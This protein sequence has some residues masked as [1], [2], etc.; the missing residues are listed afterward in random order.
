M[1]GAWTRSL[2]YIDA[3]LELVA[4]SYLASAGKSAYR[5]HSR[6]RTLPHQDCVQPQ[7]RPHPK[8]A[9]EAAAGHADLQLLDLRLGRPQ[10]AG[11]RL[12]L[13]LGFCQLAPER[14]CIGAVPG[15]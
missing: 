9:A 3:R 6:D 2:A 1:S 14:S 4:P 11:Q 7:C 10:R 8:P 13:S 12:N 5:H 15:R